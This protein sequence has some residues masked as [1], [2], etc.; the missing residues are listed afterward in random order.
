MRYV[1]EFMFS[2]LSRD[3]GQ[4]PHLLYADPEGQWLLI[5]HT[6][7]FDK[8]KKYGEIKNEEVKKKRVPCV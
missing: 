8:K 1:C 5:K 6:L 2:C 4:G 7:S 3:L